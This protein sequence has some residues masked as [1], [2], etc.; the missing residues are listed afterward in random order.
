MII[1]FWYYIL[2]AFIQGI[3]EFIPVSSSAHLLI[4][5]FILKIQDQGVIVDIIAHVGSLFAI[6]YFYRSDILGLIKNFFSVGG[7]KKLSF[8]IIVAMIPVAILGLLF[9]IFD[10]N[11]RNPYVVIFTSIVFGILL[12]VAD[13]ISKGKKEMSEITIKDSVI[14]G[15]MQAIAI[16]PGVSRSGATTTG[17]LF[18]NIKRDAALKF[19]FLLAIPAII[20]AGAGGIL[21]ILKDKVEIISMTNTLIVFF[22]SFIFSLITIKFMTKYINKN[23]FK[24][25]AIYRVILGVVLFIFLVKR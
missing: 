7:D 6:I 3:T 13:K 23:S 5:P 24:G 15:L 11:L 19:S 14:I 2:L 17:A 1:S 10:I 12:Y 25:F 16:I 8:N 18:C 22:S 20:M 9:V 4:L 21:K